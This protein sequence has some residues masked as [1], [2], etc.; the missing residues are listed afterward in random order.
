MKKIVVLI[1]ALMLAF[2]GLAIAK[3]NT[4]SGKVTA[5]SGDTV[6]IEVEKGKG[7]ALKEG[8]SVE[9]QVK[10]EK[11]APKKGMDMLQGC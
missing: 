9:M 8:V 5:V 3:G 4:V 7:A 6:T 11:K 1:A 10:E 2:S